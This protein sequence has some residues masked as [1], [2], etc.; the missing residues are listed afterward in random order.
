MAPS[1]T[2]SVMNREEALS[3][4]RAH[5]KT[6][7]IVRHVLAVEAIMRGLAEF[8]GEDSN[9]WALT[10]L[11]HDIDYELVSGDMK[12]HGLL[13][14]EILASKV[15]GET[16][17]AVKAHNHVNTGFAPES[18]MEKMLI[19]ADAISGLIVA[20]ALVM[21]SKTLEEVSL[22]TVGKKFKDK[23]FARGSD[24]DRIRLCESVGLTREELFEISLR[25]LKGIASQLGL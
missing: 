25:S 2:D 6:E 22:K 14:E 5:M 9:L 12:R 7:F 4:V 1:Q 18:K 20:C 3:L 16:I 13:A 8:Y 17:R 15:S 10:G 19:A 24:R 11:L 23:D 21:P